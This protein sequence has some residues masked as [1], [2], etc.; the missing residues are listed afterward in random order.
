M[1]AVYIAGID[2]IRFGR[3]PD[4]TPAQLAAEAALLA[5]DDCGLAIGDMQNWGSACA[6]HILQM[7]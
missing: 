7:N 3:F 2:M 5:L 4:R 6:I 1:S